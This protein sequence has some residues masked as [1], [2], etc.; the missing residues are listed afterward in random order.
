MQSAFPYSALS[1]PALGSEWYRLAR[2]RSPWLGSA[3]NAAS[4]NAV[5]ALNLAIAAI[6]VCRARLLA[7]LAVTTGTGVDQRAVGHLTLLDQIGG[8]KK[9]DKK[10]V[11]RKILAGSGILYK[12]VIHCREVAWGKCKSAAEVFCRC[13]CFG[14]LLPTADLRQV[15]QPSPASGFVLV[16]DGRGAAASRRLGLTT[17]RKQGRAKMRYSSRV[18]H[19]QS[20]VSAT[21]SRRALASYAN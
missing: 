9:E 15:V 5:F 6:G 2:L 10:L 12:A 1:R 16:S 8:K 13:F 3:L 7:V 17:C 4:A 19:R 18:F 20:P 21:Q 14:R 11:P